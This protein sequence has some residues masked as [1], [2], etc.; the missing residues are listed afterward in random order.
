[1]PLVDELVFTETSDP[2]SYTHDESTKC[3]WSIILKNTPGYD[4]AFPKDQKLSPAEQFRHLRENIDESEILL[5]KTQLDAI[6][7][8]LE[9][10]VSL[11]QVSQSIYFLTRSA[12]GASK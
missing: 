7:N 9:N 2:P 4:F 10:R 5:D 11:I 8:F 1:M 12:N 6:G 3:N